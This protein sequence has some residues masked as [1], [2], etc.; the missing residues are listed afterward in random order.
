MRPLLNRGRLDERK[1]SRGIDVIDELDAIGE[2][3][4]AHWEH[5][6]SQAFRD[7][8]SRL[9][10]LAKGGSADAAEFLAEI[11]ALHGPL[12]DASSAYKWY[13]VALSTRGYT[14][15][16]N[17]RNGSPPYYCGPDGDFR[18]ESMVSALVVELGFDRI[19]ELDRETVAWLIQVRTYKTND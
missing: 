8:V 7:G 2:Q 17:D 11:L 4:D 15:E 16:F 18:N 1:T 13:Y 9:E 19:R 3:L 10:H 12:H 6:D 14:V 5:Q